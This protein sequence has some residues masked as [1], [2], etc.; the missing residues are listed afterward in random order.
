MME[1]AQ[2]AH[3]CPFGQ[4]PRA[5]R[6]CEPEPPVIYPSQPASAEQLAMIYNL[7]LSACTS[8]EQADEFVVR[9]TQMEYKCTPSELTAMQARALINGWF[10]KHVPGLS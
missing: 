2:A 3:V 5:C 1:T 7:A 9:L 10:P 8:T 4:N 6:F